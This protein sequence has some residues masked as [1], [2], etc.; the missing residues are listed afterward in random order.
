MSYEVY[1]DECVVLARLCKGDE[2]AFEQIYFHYSK[3]IYGRLIK[4][5]KDEDIADELLQI[6]FLKIW[7]RRHQIDANQSFKAYLYRIAEN[8][9]YDY[10]RKVSRDKNMQASLKAISTELYTHIEEGI[11]Q[12]ENQAILNQ[13]IEHLPTQCKQV[14]I[15]C[16]LEGK[17]Y[18][19]ISLIMGISVSTISNHMVKANRMLREHI[20]CSK[21]EIGIILI[22]TALIKHI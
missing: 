8:L 10:F 11:L 14:F 9:V 3:Q 2:R 18:N 15:F 19:E 20:F 6:L 16:K 17:S 4:L 7:E 5:V 22:V 13:A 12:K 21:I 1:S